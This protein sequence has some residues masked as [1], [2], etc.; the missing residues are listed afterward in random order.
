M[1]ICYQDWLFKLQGPVQSENARPLVEKS[2]GMSRAEHQNQPRGPPEHGP[3]C[4][5]TGYT[6]N[7]TGP[8]CYDFHFRESLG[9]LREE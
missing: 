7:E 8:A 9:K 6:P 2:L 5:S 1:V 4:D 3:P